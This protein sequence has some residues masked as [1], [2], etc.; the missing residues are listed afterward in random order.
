MVVGYGKRVLVVSRWLAV[1]G[2]ACPAVPLDDDVAAAHVDHG[3]YA[4]THAV[5]DYRSRATA[6]VVRHFGR[7]VH[8]ATDAVAAHFANDGVTAALAMS[9]M[10]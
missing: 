1:F 2:A 5:A 4:Y 10:R 9:P 7:F 3:L 8:A 6:S